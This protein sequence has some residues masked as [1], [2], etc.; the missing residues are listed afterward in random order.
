MLRI[1]VLAAVLVGIALAVRSPSEPRAPLRLADDRLPNV[2]LL[3]IDTLRADH[4]GYIDSGPS[5]LT[6]SLDALVDGGA[7]FLAATTP[8]PTTRTA[9]AALLTGSYRGAHGV[10]TNSWPLGPRAPVLA[11]SLGRAGYRTAAFFGN[12]ILAAEYGFGR[13]FETYE[14]FADLPGRGVSKDA[15]GVE[16]AI[17]WLRS[18]PPEPWFLWVHLMDPHGPYDSAPKSVRSAVARDDPRAERVLKAA[19]RNTGLG[20]LPRYQAIPGVRRASVYRWRYRAEVR[21]SDAQAGKLLAALDE[22]VLTGSTLTFLTSDHGEGLGDHEY[23]FQHGGLADEGSIAVPLAIR[24]PGRVRAGARLDSPVSLVDV[25]PT[26]LG[27]LGLQIPPE[28]EG[29]DLSGA[30]AI[31]RPSRLVEA[32]VFSAATLLSGIASVR[33]GRWKLVHTPGPLAAGVREND[34]WESDY[35]PAE[36]FRLYDVRDDPGET[37]DL[38]GEHPDRVARMRAV[39][40]A[41]EHAQ[42]LDAIQ[43]LE[44][45]APDERLRDMLRS[46]GY[47]D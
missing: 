34:P 11:E 21:H 37:R 46:L 27:G 25:A 23:F 17:A 15:V 3:T 38:A 24:L 42:A 14:S 30:L 10:H 7:A 6:P 8:A 28:M 12:G 19:R 26:L 4:L 18:S 31:G 43:R 35:E 45:E 32:P 47:V 5:D 29:R 13:G 20:V 44:P 16:R 39:L 40:E 33:S 41:W 9:T 2:L 36:S 1:F 22:L